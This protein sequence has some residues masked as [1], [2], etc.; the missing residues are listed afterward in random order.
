MFLPVR[1]IYHSQALIGVQSGAAAVRL[2]LW[3][4]LGRYKVV[5]SA[6][7]RGAAHLRV[8]PARTPGMVRSTG[9]LRLSHWEGG[10]S[11]LRSRPRGP[12]SR[13]TGVEAE[14]RRRVALPNY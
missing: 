14:D 2:W 6:A 4:G 7:G 9:P 5:P 8:V 13:E 3:Y 1:I 11:S 10:D 12:A